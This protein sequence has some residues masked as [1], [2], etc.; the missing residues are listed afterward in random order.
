MLYYMSQ[1]TIPRVGL[2][3]ILQSVYTLCHTNY[4]ETSSA[5]FVALLFFFFEYPYKWDILRT[6][7]KYIHYPALHCKASFRFLPFFKMGTQVII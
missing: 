2:T 7:A 3:T 6:N 5:F 4:K 1:F